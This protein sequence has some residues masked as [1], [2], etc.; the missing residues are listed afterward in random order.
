MTMKEKNGT[1]PIGVLALDCETTVWAKGNPF[2]RRNKLCAIATTHGVYKIEYDEEPYGKALEEVQRQIDAA[3]ILIGFNIKFDLHWLRRYGIRFAHR[4]I[5]DCQIAQHIIE[6]QCNPYPSLEG[7][8]QYWKCGEK[9]HDIESYWKSGIDT[10]GI[11]WDF[12]RDRAA[13][14]VALTDRVYNCQLNNVG[15]KQAQLIRLDCLDLIVLEEMEYNGIRYDCAASLKAAEELRSE[16]KAMDAELSAVVGIDGI[17]FNSNDQLSAVLYGGKIV[18]EGRQDYEFTYKDGRK[19]IKSRVVELVHEMSRLVAPLPKTELAKEGYW[20]TGEAI[21]GSLKAKGKA[22]RII[23]IINK[24][25]KMEKL[26]GTY[27]EGIPKLIREM[28]WADNII[29]GNLNQCVAVTG[30]LSSSKPN[31]QNMSPEPLAYMRS[32]Y[33]C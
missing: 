8:A 14:D 13:D 19:A 12:I 26:A 23:E 32:N 21:L 3:E 31:M 11:P 17:N 7:T 5:W 6:C 16:I 28:D 29:H 27:L 1:I 30:R 9:N 25:T 24:R 4:R 2:S 15:G 18:R 10:T 33:D 22:K 20:S